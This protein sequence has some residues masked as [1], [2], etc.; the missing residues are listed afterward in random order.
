MNG[1][2]ERLIQR[3]RDPLPG[4]R[5]L[6][7]PW[8]GRGAAIG[9]QTP[10][11]PIASSVEAKP[12]EQ[13]QISPFTEAVS[14]TH[15]VP[16]IT[17]GSATLPSTVSRNTSSVERRLEPALFSDTCGDSG[18]P[19]TDQQ[20][21]PPRTP[22]S[23]RQKNSPEPIYARPVSSIVP[24]V[25]ERSAGSAPPASHSVLEPA[26]APAR[27]AL[28]EPAVVRPNSKTYPR[29]AVVAD[30]PFQEEAQPVEVTISIGHIELRSPQPVERPRKPA[31][32]PRV[33]LN[34]FLSRRQGERS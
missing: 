12:P 23:V 10:L 33:S 7:E 27:K 29:G 2:L 15:T 22:V 31:F 13:I 32:R 24:T 30:A 20:Q 5:P 14:A 3:A 4:I 9:A 8:F 11:D 28:T 6:H 17:P 34:D 26:V 21:G 16:R 19:T 18:I 1:V 25:P